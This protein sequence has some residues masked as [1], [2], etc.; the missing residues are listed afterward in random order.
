M[1]TNLHY[2]FGG[3]N[4][5]T[6]YYFGNN[7]VLQKEKEFCSKSAAFFLGKWESPIVAVAVSAVAPTTANKGV[8]PKPVYDAIAAWT[9]IVLVCE[10]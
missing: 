7:Y 1:Y 2:M 4:N 10:G 5:Y 3:N 9:F 6:D 8:V